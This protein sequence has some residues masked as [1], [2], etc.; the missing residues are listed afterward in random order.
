LARLRIDNSH[1]NI[2]KRP[3]AVVQARFERIV[4]VADSRVAVSF[5]QAVDIAYALYAKIDDALDL[6]WSPDRNTCSQGGKIVRRTVWML[7]EGE[8]HIRRSIKH[9]TTLALD[10]CHR[11][12]GIE[13]SLKHDRAAMCHQG[14]QRVHATER[15]E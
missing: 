14:E 2:V 4:C 8:R 6:V 1:F 13:V 11:F 15:P 5:R 10:Q 9:G 3:A 7:G 12:T